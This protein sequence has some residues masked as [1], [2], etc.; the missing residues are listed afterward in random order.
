MTDRKQW[1]SGFLEAKGEVVVDKRAV[2]ILSKGEVS[3]LPVGVIKVSGDFNEGDLIFVRDERGDHIASG[4]ANYD[5]ISAKKVIGKRS[6]EVRE[7]LGDIKSELIHVDNLVV[8]KAV[9]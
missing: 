6:D 3:L 7:I 5:N 1:I 4:Y 9:F 2:K 8:I